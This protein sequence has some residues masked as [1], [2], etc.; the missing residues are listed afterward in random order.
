M[1]NGY[2]PMPMQIPHHAIHL[3]HTHTTMIILTLFVATIFY[4]YFGLVV[5]VLSFSRFQFSQTN[6]Q[7]TLC[8]LFSTHTHIKRVHL[9]L[10]DFFIS[11]RNLYLVVVV[12]SYFLASKGM[13]TFAA[14][15]LDHLFFFS[16]STHHQ[17]HKKEKQQKIE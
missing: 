9:K 7:Q 1:S 3:K 11:G 6:R 4:L 13:H 17:P 5:V 10:I 8:N 15:S 2:T 16:L 12:V 14:Q